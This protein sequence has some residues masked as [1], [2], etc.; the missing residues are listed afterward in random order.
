[1][2]LMRLKT[3]SSLNKC[4]SKKLKKVNEFTL[5]GRDLLTLMS[6]VF[7]IRFFIFVNLIKIELL[8]IDSVSGIL[9][10]LSQWV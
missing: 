4:V 3:D 10:R 2:L 5:I 8:V 1:M 7:G 9:T 6:L